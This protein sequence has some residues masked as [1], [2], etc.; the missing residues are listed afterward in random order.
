M[1]NS[2]TTKPPHVKEKKSYQPGLEQ[3]YFSQIWYEQPE[4]S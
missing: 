2:T 3:K 1:G 4:G